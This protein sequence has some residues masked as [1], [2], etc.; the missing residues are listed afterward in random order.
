MLKHGLA[1]TEGTGDEAGTA[2]NDGVEG[3]DGAHTCLQQLEW[4]GLLLV[5]GHSKLH[6]P[7]LNH[8]N[9]YVLASL[10]GEHGNGVVHLVLACGHDALNH[11]NTLHL[12]GSHDLQ[13]LVVLLNLAQP[14]TALH[15]VAGLHYGFKVPQTVL[16]Q[17]SGVLAT[18]QEH[19]VH[20]VQVVLQTIVVLTQHTGA[21]LNLQLVS[22]E[23]GLGA[24]LQ[25]TCTLEYLNV[26]I[27][28]HDLDD[29]GHQAV[30]ASC[31][32]AYLALQDR[33]VHTE[34][35]HVGDYATNYTFCHI[36]LYYFP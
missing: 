35:H 26:H 36:L 29:L 2:L 12:E 16:V 9:V 10:G 30:A 15:L 23:F 7:A 11:G 25:A 17:G 6:G 34:C 22:G 3:V 14:C 19:A 20:L 28:A 32:V 13:G 1:S 21:Q 5:V 33:S 24:Y 27:A 18:A 4:T 31:N 8:G